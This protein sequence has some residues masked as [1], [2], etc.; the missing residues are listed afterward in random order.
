MTGTPEPLRLEELRGALARGVIGC[1][2]DVL[3]T[4]DSTNDEAQRRAHSN[5]KSGSVIFAETQTAGRGQRRSE[6]ASAWRKG[7]WCSV[8]LRPN[9][10]LADSPQL[11][12]WAAETVRDLVCSEFEIEAE[13]KL[14]N[15]LLARGKKIAG[16][17]VEM[18]A[19][20][21]AAH[22]AILGLGLNV[23]QQLED[24]PEPIRNR[25]T[26]L[27]IVLGRE[28][29]RTALAQALLRALDRAWRW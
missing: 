15:D 2:I 8:L 6:W 13:L 22:V 20:S 11:S 18:R 5:S 27:A 12:R 10:N 17:L 19:Q 21:S 7:I 9:L 25:A 14:P 28:V 4:V 1:E 23:N 16:V 24:F 29:D 3:E 26:S